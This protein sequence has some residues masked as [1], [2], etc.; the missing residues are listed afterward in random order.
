MAPS[1]TP[2]TDLLVE[3]LTRLW[4]EGY[5]A[6]VIAEKLGGGMTRCGVLGKINRLGLPRRKP[7]PPARGQA[8]K[9]VKRGRPI[10]T[11]VRT[12]RPVFQPSPTPSEPPAPAP[13]QPPEKPRM[14]RL[15]LMQL[16]DHHCRFPFGDPLRRPFFFCGADTTD[17][18][19]YC[20]YHFERAYIRSRTR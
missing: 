20:D 19:I 8:R 16:Q 6:S 9:P 5:S 10:P 3:E 11:Y 4:A 14:R 15:Q 2:W 1:W 12:R 13:A 17:G 7:P 18:K